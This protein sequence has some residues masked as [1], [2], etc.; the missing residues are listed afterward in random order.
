MK[1]F[2][3]HD[4]EDVLQVRI[5]MYAQSFDFSV[6]LSLQCCMPC[7]SGLFSRY[8]DEIQMLLF[9][10]AEWH[11]LAKLRQ[12]TDSTLA[13]LRSVTKALGS[14]LR[15]FEKHIAPSYNTYEL[16]KET[17]ARNRAQMRKNQGKVTTNAS[18]KSSTSKR[19]KTFTLYTFKLHGIG[20]YPESIRL[21]GTTDSYSTQIVRT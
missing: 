15:R 11:F 7:F 12:H 21:F 9:L 3:A 18:G 6:T 20:D 8:D 14:C 5:S 2:A 10:L 13:T 1:K 16:D 17:A 19:L 4:F